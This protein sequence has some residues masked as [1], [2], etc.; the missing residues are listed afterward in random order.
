MRQRQTAVLDPGHLA[1]DTPPSARC[2]GAPDLLCSQGGHFTPS[3]AQVQGVWPSSACS[4]RSKKG[5]GGGCALT[6][7][8]GHSSPAQG[9]GLVSTRPGREQGAPRQNSRS[10]CSDLAHLLFS[11]LYS[12]DILLTPTQAHTCSAPPQLLGLLSA[13]Q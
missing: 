12:L 5:R 8:R 6:V 4:N 2:G 3:A 1:G 10:P 9:E 11:C 7:P 13:P